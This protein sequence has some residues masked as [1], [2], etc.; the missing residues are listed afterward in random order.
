MRWLSIKRDVSVAGKVDAHRLSGVRADLWDVIRF[1]LSFASPATLAR[2]A[3]AMVKKMGSD[4][5]RLRNYY[6]EPRFGPQDPYRGLH[7]EIRILDNGRPRYFEVQLVT[8]GRDAVGLIDHP[9]VHKPQLE[10]SDDDH[11]A[12][13]DA[14]RAAANIADAAFGGRVLDTFVSTNLRQAT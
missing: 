2:V 11:R 7:L 12:W 10:Y 8:V 6:L 4:V 1:R 13:L 9:F 5:V 3:S 14:M